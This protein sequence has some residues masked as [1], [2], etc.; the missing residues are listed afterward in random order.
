MILTSYCGTAYHVLLHKRNKNL[1]IDP[2]ETHHLDSNMQSRDY[3][4]VILPCSYASIDFLHLKIFWL[5]VIRE[6]PIKI[7]EQLSHWKLESGSE[8]DTSTYSSDSAKWDAFVVS[9]NVVQ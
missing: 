6:F 5:H 4:Q 3:N 1:Y 2:L 8:C 9:P 7:I